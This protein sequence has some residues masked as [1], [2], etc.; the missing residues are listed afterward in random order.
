MRSVVVTANFLQIQALSWNFSRGGVIE[1]GSEVAEGTTR[2]GSVW[3]PLEGNS[4][5]E[6]LA[7]RGSSPTV[8]EGALA[9]LEPSLTVGLP[10]RFAGCANDKAIARPIAPPAPVTKAVLP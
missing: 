10:P 9:M 8:K 4:S 3:I 2:L 6:D 5:P 7:A 1:T